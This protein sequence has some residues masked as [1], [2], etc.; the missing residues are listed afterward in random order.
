MNLLIDKSNYLEAKK[1]F[2]SY[3]GNLKN[4]S[5]ALAIVEYIRINKGVALFIADDI[6]NANEIKE[7]ID[8]YNSNNNI[9]VFDFP[10][11]EV[12]PYDIFSPHQDITATRLNLLNKAKSFKSTIIIVTIEALIQRLCPKD[13]IQSKSFFIKVADKIN[14]SS[15]TAK[16]IKIGYNRVTTV[17]EH[18]E[19]NVKGSIIDIFPSA[20]KKPYRVDLFDEDVE[21]IRTFDSQSQLS[22]ANV[23]E[24]SLI[25]AKEIATDKDAVTKFLKKYQNIF[26]NTSSYIYSEVSDNRFPAG[27]EFYLPLFFDTTCTLFDYLP[28]DLI[29]FRQTKLVT[30]VDKLFIDIDKRYKK[31]KNDID[32]PPLPPNNIFISKEELFSK[33][34]PLSQIVLQPSKLENENVNSINYPTK[35]LTPLTIQN[36]APNPLQRLVN[37]IK[38]FKGRILLLAES[39]SRKEL[40]I[41]LLNN[42]NINPDNTKDYHSFITSKTPLAICL[43]TIKKGLLLNDIA[44]I[45]E[46]NI[47][48]ESVVKQQRI[49]RAKHKDFTDSI[50]NLVELNISDPVVHES[51]GVGR[52]LGLEVIKHD[53][54]EQ[55][56]LKIKYA[57][58][59][60]LLVP[61][62]S[63]N[64]V[65]RYSSVAIENAPLH[66]LGSQQWAKIKK[67]AQETIYDIA[68]EL[69]EIYARREN[70]KTTRFIEPSDSYTSFISQFPF[71]ETEDQINATID[72]LKDMTSSK[73]MD[74]LICGDVGFGKTEIAMRAAFLAVENNKQ[75]A[76]LV[77]TTLLTDQH[78]KTFKERFIMHGV[79]IEMLSRFKTQKQQ[80]EIIAK[81]AAGKIDIIIGTHKLLQKNIKYKKLGLVIIDEEHRFGV[82]QKEFFKAIRGECD[83]LTM[84]ATPIPRTLSMALGALREMS[85]IATHPAKR[86]AVKT[87]VNEW[88][89]ALLQEACMRELHRGGQIFVLHNDIDSIDNMAK[90][91]AK[92]VPKAKI[93][94]AHG[95]MPTKELELVMQDFYH[96]RFKILV[97]TTIIENGIDIPSANTIII[98]DAQN[99]GLSQLHQLRGR[100]GR[101]HHRAYAYLIVKSF[102]SLSKN[103]K[104][105]LDAIESLEELGVG[106]MLANHDLEIRG[107]GELLGENQ[108]G[109]IQEIGFNLYRELLDRTINAMKKN[110]SF[111]LTKAIDDI[112]VDCG[113]SCIIPSDYL[114][115]VH[116]RLMFYKRIANALNPK[117]LKDIEFE[118]MDRFGILPEAI[119]NLF[120]NT[121]L[122]MTAKN[123]GIKKIIL[124][125]NNA[126]IIFTES[127]NID[128]M[129]IINLIQ[130]QPQVYKFIKNDNKLIINKE[131]QNDFTRI[132]NIE[133][134]LNDL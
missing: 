18:G 61:I 107:A 127:P 45:T 81:L 68:T 108:S 54:E 89:D 69:L 64:L 82:R 49:R 84:T 72:I 104:K 83:I 109:R 44:I 86:L 121:K 47:F 28:K 101:S 43:S 123:I 35:L 99:F 80:K 98:N 120:L 22:I 67:K 119:K 102:H 131:M 42:H 4:S 60:K 17:M 12:L 124:T 52:Y 34:K 97:C 116:M 1:Q 128:P 125:D 55:E 106:F 51:Y 14:L 36:Q 65:S 38:K 112:E 19:F 74:R 48:G 76:V 71:E 93:R 40:L 9:K 118:M 134:F 132:N 31:T 59:S 3:W 133:L 20:A 122:K 95:R 11:W 78:C 117:E 87:F 105:R 100:V 56:F 30:K 41:D 88:D 114:P 73:P 103:A 10:D 75:V 2:K 7:E 63:L 129:K 39:L 113:I 13:F 37:F 57:N 53:D 24:I 50:K 92:L 27:I 70:K 32:R 91:I 110:I 96:Q 23:K 5:L 29:V 33:I 62:T 58:N 6:N 16:L 15:L 115:D 94:V 111:D 21:S 8:F 85:I 46:T 126:I 79:N 90:T 25:P 77:P 130:S 66:R 26:T